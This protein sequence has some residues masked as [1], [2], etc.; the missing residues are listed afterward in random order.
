[1]W[2]SQSG[3]GSA[4]VAAF[5]MT[6]PDSCGFEVPSLASILLGHALSIWE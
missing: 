3:A 2:A 1:M 4:K 6:S 5:S